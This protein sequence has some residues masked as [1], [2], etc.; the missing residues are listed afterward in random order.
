MNLAFYPP[1]Y[2]TPSG[3]IPFLRSIPVVPLRSTIGYVITIPA[4]LKKPQTSLSPV[5]PFHS[6]IG[7]VIIIPAGLKKLQML[8]IPVVPFHSTIGYVITIPAGLKI[9]PF[10]PSVLLAFLPSALLAFP[11]GSHL[12]R[13]IPME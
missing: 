12:T 2:V 1:Y 9:I 7:Y 4:G 10:L 5:V 13:R 6:T 3:F 8:L 11:Y